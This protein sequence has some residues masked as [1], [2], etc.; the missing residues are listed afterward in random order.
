MLRPRIIPT[1][2]LHD[3]ALVK[4]VRF[5]RFEYI[6]DP[7]NT[8]RIFNELEVDELMF[9]D[10]AATRRGQEPDLAK[11]ADI[12]DECFMPL[13]YGGGITT[14]DQAREILALGFE[15]VMINSHAHVDP[16]LIA[17][18]AD[19]FG[20]QAVIGGIDVKRGRDGRQPSVFTRSGTCN[21][22]KDPVT[23]AQHLEHLGAGEV[24]LTSVDREGTWTGY[25]LELVRAVAGAISVPLIA[26]GGAGSLADISAVIHNAGASAAAV[27]SF[28]VYQK[29]GAGVLVNF[30]SPE[31]LTTVLTGDR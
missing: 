20:S 9:L 8:V 14:L 11:L 7:A 16:G 30:P 19:H 23:W 26:N 1:L 31:Q 3:G 21:T 4:T 29:H 10:I 25:D 15:K 13:A 27:G 24:L 5:G 12:A 18:I 6:G 2:L 22:G 28:V 17:R